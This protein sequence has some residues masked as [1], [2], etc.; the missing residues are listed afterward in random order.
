[1][2]VCYIVYLLRIGIDLC[3]CVCSVR[4]MC[5]FTWLFNSIC[6]SSNSPYVLFSTFVY[7][8]W[9]WS[10]CGSVCM[11][12]CVCVTFTATVHIVAQTLKDKKK[13]SIEATSVLLVTICWFPNQTLWFNEFP[14]QDVEWALCLLLWL[15]TASCNGFSY[16]WHTHMH[17]NSSTAISSA[18][19]D[20]VLY[21]KE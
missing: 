11:G 18:V 8:W 16:I 13:T 10:V 2:F 5:V 9:T 4:S 7:V 1:M 21:S 15:H 6:L 12:V 17:T 3:V 20:S 19:V 14:V